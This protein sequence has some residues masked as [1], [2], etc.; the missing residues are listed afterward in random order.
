MRIAEMTAEKAILCTDIRRVEEQLA[1]TMDQLNT[2]QHGR[3]EAHDVHDQLAKQLAESQT[4]LVNAEVSLAKAQQG[5]T[6]ASSK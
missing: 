2:E 1:E 5:Q 3:Q 6:E 4:K